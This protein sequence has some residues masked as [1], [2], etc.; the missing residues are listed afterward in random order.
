MDTVRRMVDTHVNARTS[1]T[2]LVLVALAQ[3]MVILD[4]TVV[5]VALPTI[6]D[7]LGFAAGQ[8]QWV[9]TAYL[10]FTGGL[11][12]L[13][14]RLADLAGR[15][16]VFLTG[17]AI[18]TGSSLASGLAWSP[19]SLIVARAAQGLG[20]ALLLPSALSIVTTA[21][22]GHQRTVA[23][24]IWGALATA[25]AAV[26]VLLGGVITST[27]G[28]QWVFF[29][30]VPVGVAVFALVPRVVAAGAPG[31]RGALD[32]AG[33]VTVMGGLV[34]LVLAIQGAPAHG[35]TSARTLALGAA[36]AGLL[37][38]FA[39]IERSTAR[40]LVPPATW[41]VQSL[42]SSA[43]VML[44]ASG[45]LVGTFFLNTLFLQHV[46]G[47]SPIETGLAF[48][49]LTLV[50]LLGAHAAQHLLPKVGSRPPIAAGLLL[51]AAGAYLLSRVTAQA[52]YAADLLP[53]FV[54][55]GVGVGMTLVSVSVAAMADVGH[56]TAGLASGLM[57]TAH[58][59][60]AALGVAVLGSIALTG[61]GIAGG[62]GDGFLVASAVAAVT[63]I[64]TA[65]ALPS[66]RP[67]P[68]AAGGIH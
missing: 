37:A 19:E 28:W 55:L 1:W 17:L 21:Y 46:M 50:I 8:L 6:G 36:A 30:N 59:L 18:F 25:G 22:D 4:G 32:L 47:A 65:L 49:P 3:F 62:Y 57:T 23:L 26:G 34:A 53:G 56:E 61:T 27:L 31:A 20:A 60:G 14:G 33:A 35:W 10:L 7:D 15:R 39:A 43:S 66:V 24:A 29:I 12:L 45:I 9:V 41:R 52:D 5:N 13:G 63:A 44:I 11:M 48:L 58:E 67:A 42:V 38:A 2:V 64:V 54:A 68:G 16:V 51:M 40:P